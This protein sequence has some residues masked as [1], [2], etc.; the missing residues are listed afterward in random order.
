MEQNQQNKSY[1]LPIVM[2]FALFFMIAFVTNLQSPMGVIVKSQFGASNFQ[3][4][5]GTLANFI[6]YAFMGIPAGQMLQR[7]GYK[8]TALTAVIVGFV[9]VCIIFLSGAM[10]SF[11]LWQ[12]FLC[13][14]SM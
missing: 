6:A 14:C 9:G 1:L 5:L 7:M 12:V 8:K 3:A 11:A 10:E 13:V 2:M 4:Q